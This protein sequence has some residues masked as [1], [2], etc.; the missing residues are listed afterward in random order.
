M[1][2]DRSNTAADANLCSIVDR[3]S[4][5]EIPRDRF[6]SS[7]LV[8]SSRERVREELESKHRPFISPVVSNL[9]EEIEN[10]KER[11]EYYFSVAC[12]PCTRLS[13]Y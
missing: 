12:G 5:A 2:T 4:T 10:G 8:T 9:R 13:L 11:E 3:V 7:I 1:Y 6:P